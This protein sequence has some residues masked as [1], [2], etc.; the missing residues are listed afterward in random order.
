MKQNAVIARSTT[1]NTDVA[2]PERET[3][4]LRRLFSLACLRDDEKALL[5]RA[6]GST[7][8]IP[9]GR[10]II[11]EGTPVAS[12]SILLSGWAYRARQFA[13]GRM[14]ILGLLLPG[15]LIGRCRHRLPL[16]ATT[17]LSATPVVLCAAPAATEGSGLAEAYALSAALKELYLFRQIARLGRLSAYERTID[18]L[19]ETRERT[20]LSGLMDGD[21]F[22][23][24]LTQSLMADL[25]GITDV[26]LNRTLRGL[27][28]DGWLEIQRG[29]VSLRG[30]D[31]LADQVDFRP[32]RV[33]QTQ[34]ASG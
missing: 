28:A 3:P 16:A 10:E 7:R 1:M 30:V 25:L 18:W 11:V 2:V 5:R 13:D 20:D 31:R 23:M 8:S 12:P 27:R 19:L 9:A 34:P 26:H 4:A 6:A 33:S 24:P 32:A 15:E 22:P 21:E 29:R 14:Q 17:I